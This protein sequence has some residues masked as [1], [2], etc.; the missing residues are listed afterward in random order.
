MERRGFAVL[1]EKRKRT[2]KIPLGTPLEI[3][4]GRYRTEGRSHFHFVTSLWV[5]FCK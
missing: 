1:Y 4:A 3:R 5:A 2:I